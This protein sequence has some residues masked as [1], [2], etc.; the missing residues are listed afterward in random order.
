M[1]C[2]TPATM[3]QH[4][5]RTAEAAEVAISICPCH[6]T[7][8]WC[9]KLFHLMHQHLFYP[10]IIKLNLRV[11]IF[12]PRRSR[13][14]RRRGPFYTLATPRATNDIYLKPNIVGN[15]GRSSSTEKNAHYSVLCTYVR[16]CSKENNRDNIDYVGVVLLQKVCVIYS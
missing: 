5:S 4:S 16:T 10:G 14:C 9:G 11:M 15:C 1:E 3:L 6:T 7:R 12:W 13:P 8:F 2:Y